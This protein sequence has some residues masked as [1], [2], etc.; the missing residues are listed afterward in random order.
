MF[1]IYILVSVFIYS[2]AFELQRSLNSRYLGKEPTGS[3]QVKLLGG[4]KTSGNIIIRRGAHSAWGGICDDGWSKNNGD[5]I[6]RML[7]F[8]KCIAITVNSKFGHLSNNRIWLDNVRCNGSEAS[9]ED[10][11][12]SAWGLHNCDQKEVAGVYCGRQNDFALKKSAK[13]FKEYAIRMKG[14]R[15]PTEGRIEVNTGYS[16]GT[17]CAD[18]WT[19]ME[20][21]VA[22]RQL[23]LKYARS[24]TTAP[25]F[26]GNN[27]SKII[28][29]L[30]CTGEESN[31]AECHHENVGKEVSCRDSN[32]IAGVLCTER[33]PDLQPN[34]TL[35]EET[36]YL[37]DRPMFLMQCAMEEG[38]AS[39]T[40]FHIQ[41][42][43]R[44][45]QIYRRRLLRFSSATKNVGT[46]DFHPF[47]HMDDWEWH[48]CHMHFH[49]M[50]VFAHYDL[51][52]KNGK[53]VAEG[54]KASF[55]LEDVQC[56]SGIAKRYICQGY[57]QQ[58]ISVGCSDI[59]THEIDCQ[60]ID[61]TEVEPGDYIF[62]MQVNPER[63]IAELSYANN[64]VVC[65]MRYAGVSATVTDCKL[66]SL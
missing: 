50:E 19:L 46:A 14:G 31:L 41:R 34:V 3:I 39:S 42:T 11:H 48:S 63:K 62:R 47:L 21:M 64:A 29:G 33:L 23:G 25:Y 1:S 6:C 8:G 35:L 65:K 17:I 7:G 54:H 38:C 16:W 2:T 37:Q 28:S 49:S 24:H 61:M 66:C 52:D 36:I 43:Y 13:T 45:W 57:S 32:L 59:Y 9:L 12:L 15:N 10:C 56:D 60:W 4:S 40:A 27:V 22:C 58:G 44:D 5:V 30:H 51:F 55:C 18:T 26:G 20:A 53:R